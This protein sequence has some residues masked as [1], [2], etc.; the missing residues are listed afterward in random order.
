MKPLLVT[1]GE[2]AGIGPDLCLRLAA[3]SLP[4]VILCNKEL[5]LDRAQKLGLQIR[6]FDY[7]SQ[8]KLHN[9][10]GELTVLS[11]PCPAKVVPGELNI[12]N[13]NYVI[14]MLSI[15]AERCLNGEFSGLVTAPV[16]KGILNEAGINFTGHTEFF[17]KIF[18]ATRVVMMLAAKEMKVALVTTHLPLKDVPKAISEKLVIEIIDSLC[19]GLKTYFGICN[20]KIFVSGLNPHAG[21]YGYLGREEIDEIIPALTYLKQEGVDVCGPMPADS[22]FTPQNMKK[23]D[24]FVAMY[25]DQGLAVLKAI[26]FRSAVNV[27]LGLPIIRVSVD[28]GTALELAGSK[29]AKP[30]SLLAAVEM[31]LLMVENKKSLEKKRAKVIT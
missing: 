13:A 17:A 24:A 4:V 15:G 21:E 3:Y 9:K 19:D 26:S 31:A 28:H 1:S 14:N 2:P 25:H 16:H 23:C 8:G 6:L 11:I 10:P 20:P 22:M 12:D 30:D 29:K 18:K 5:L 27:T 7:K